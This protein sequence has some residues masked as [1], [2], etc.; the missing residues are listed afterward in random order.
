MYYF[1]YSAIYYL[2][3]RVRP[4]AFCVENVFSP[5]P[6]HLASFLDFG[7]ECTAIYRK[8]AFWATLLKQ[9]GY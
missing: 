6:Q 1:Y 4:I 2:M 9:Y 5:K 8:L 7:D 3:N